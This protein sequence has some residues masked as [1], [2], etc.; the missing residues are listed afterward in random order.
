[1]SRLLPDDIAA[2]LPPFFR[3]EN[4]DADAKVCPLKIFDPCGRFTL[5]VVEYEPV[6]RVFFGYVVSPLGP[7]C[8]EWGYASL[9]ELEAVRNQLGLPLEVDVHWKPGPVPLDP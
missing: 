3:T 8:D 6:H 4:I 2:Q 1:M 5:Y 7:D 9:D